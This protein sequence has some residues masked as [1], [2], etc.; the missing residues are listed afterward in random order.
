MAHAR[1]LR[2]RIWRSTSACSASFRAKRRITRAPST[3]ALAGTT[4]VPQV[5]VNG[6]HVGGADEL[7]KE[8]GD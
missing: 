8:L 2:S 5:F 6:R 4:L 7:V 1:P 3:F